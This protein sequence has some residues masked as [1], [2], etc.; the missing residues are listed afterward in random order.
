MD[1]NFFIIY[2]YSFNE[3]ENKPFN[4]DRKFVNSRNYTLVKV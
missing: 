4:F 2:I 3:I 1:A